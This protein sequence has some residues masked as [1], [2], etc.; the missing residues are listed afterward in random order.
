MAG[1]GQFGHPAQGIFAYWINAYLRRRP[2]RY[3]GFGGTGLQVRDCLHPRDL[4]ELLWRQMNAAGG[5]DT[6]AERIQNVSGGIDS[7]MSLRELSAWCADRFGRHD[8]GVDPVDRPFDLPWVVL[9]PTRAETQW[10]WRPRT[11]V[12][13]ILTEI[14]T[15]AEAHPDWLDISRS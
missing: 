6:P 11:P 12:G 13:D 9:D 14:A 4:A 8:I 5:A 1:A 10:A 3:I 2:L 7:A 15:H